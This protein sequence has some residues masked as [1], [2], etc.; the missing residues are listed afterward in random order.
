MFCYRTILIFLICITSGWLV[1][2]NRVPSSEKE[3]HHS[4]ELEDLPELANKIKLLENEVIELK[5]HYRD[6]LAKREQVEQEMAM[7]LERNT[8][9]THGTYEGILIHVDG[10][11]KEI[12]STLP[13]L[14]QY[15]EEDMIGKKVFEFM[16]KD[17]IELARTNIIQNYTQPYEVS[18]IQKD[19][20]VKE[21]EVIGSEIEYRNQKARIASLRDISDRRNVE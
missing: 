19:G 9:F 4:R 11:I 16:H 14:F 15:S 8:W 5:A 21:V 3:K 13:K 12:N 20:S 10:V 18:I 7:V 17:S 6:E 1:L 2:G